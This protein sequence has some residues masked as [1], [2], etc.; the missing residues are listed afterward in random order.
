MYQY[1]ALD[2]ELVQSR[3][4]QFADQT[5]RFLAGELSEEQYR[6]LRLQ[7]GL[8]KQRFAPMLRVAIPYGT[9]SSEQLREL[10][11]IAEDFDKGY[12]HFTT[13]QNIQ[14][15]WP[16]LEDVPAI[17][18]RLSTVEMH[19]IQT[20]GNCIRN[21]SSDVYAGVA[22]DE[23]MDPRPWCELL[24]QWST[25]HPEF[26]YLPR[27]FKIA[28]SAATQDRAATYVHDI[29]LQIHAVD[30]APRFRV[31][32]GGGLGRTPVLGTVIR[33]AL[34]PYDLRAY[35]EAILRVYN[36][37]GRR[38]N[39]YKARIKILVKET[40]AAIFSELVEAEFKNL[41]G[42]EL[43]ISDAEIAH[44]SSFF[45]RPDYATAE[46][47]PVTEAAAPPTSWISQN[48][49]AHQQKG[50]RSVVVSLKAPDEPPGDAS[51][52]QMRT[53]ALLAERYGFGEIRVSHEQ[54]LILPDIRAVDV[55][56]VYAALQQAGLA[57]ANAGLAT[58]VICCP[59]LDF[60]SLANASS[61]SVA[62]E[63]NE[64]LDD[65]D[66]LEGLGELRLNMSGCM[67]GC[68]HHSVGHIG[69]LGVDKKGE[70]WYQISLGGSSKNDASLGDRL[71]AALSRADI[72]PAIGRLLERYRE[73]RSGDET[74]LDTYRR[75]GIAAFK[76]AV[77]V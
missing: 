21:I 61:I 28:V 32:V 37:L 24:R 43:Q 45:P 31:I 25:L 48:V 64:L 38:D 39:K 58:D 7:N 29:G 2:H 42:G 19:A 66:E 13:R 22:P 54:N 60:C 40:G 56:A 44:Y 11:Q 55:P 4:R 69:I 67:N 71:G 6:P 18:D 46:A 17:L 52:E 70:E 35:C 27:K 72:V 74:F 50:W 73:L 62:R 51:A 41:Q 15:N 59:G 36:R 10:A 8:Y 49:K 63:L 34:E 30:G 76:E 5:R 53:V 3:V 23:W 77:Y 26:A 33:E 1:D 20:S 14:F 68:G 65:Q 12:G 75:V 57:T 16:R 9:L 47:A